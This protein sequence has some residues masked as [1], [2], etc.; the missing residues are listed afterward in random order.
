MENISI[1]SRKAGEPNKIYLND[2]LHIVEGGNKV[3]VTHGNRFFEGTREEAIEEYRDR[4]YNVESV[5]F[6][7]IYNC[8]IIECVLTRG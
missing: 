8:L 5:W 7:T 6:S 1:R 4:F 2:F 3:R